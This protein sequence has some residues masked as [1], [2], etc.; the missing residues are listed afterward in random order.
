M[1]FLKIK[2]TCLYIHD[3]ERAKKFYHETLELP[4]IS[5]VEGKHIFFRAGTSVLLCFNPEDSRHKE[6]P[7]AHY[8]GG[9]QHFA[10][11]VNKRD[12]ESAKTWITNKGIRITDTVT[13]K[14]GAESF[15]F[16]D[17]EGNVLEIVP[18]EAI[19]D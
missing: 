1:K 3:L 8:G 18:D 9:K 4:L 16:E 14:G 13:W 10:F 12:Y 5:H 7:P 11:E 15:Y 2:E 19:W 6:S 17:P